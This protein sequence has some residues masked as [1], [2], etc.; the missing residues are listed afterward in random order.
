[1][2]VILLSVGVFIVLVAL[3]VGMQAA[4]NEIMKDPTDWDGDR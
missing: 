1:M 4:L 2:K 3:F